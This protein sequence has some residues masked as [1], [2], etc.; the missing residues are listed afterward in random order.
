MNTKQ[1]CYV[2]HYIDAHDR[3]R[4]MYEYWVSGRG[5]FP[6]DMLRYDLAWP[7]TSQD[8]AALDNYTGVRTIRS[9]KLQSYCEPTI[10]RWLSF[11]W[12]VGTE[13]LEGK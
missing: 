2:H 5:Q 8:A 11:C 4:K 7:A 6:L 10:D 9:V 1:R 13:K 12:S 3:P